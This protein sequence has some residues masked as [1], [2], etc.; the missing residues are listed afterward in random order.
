M[1][2]RPCA[3]DRQYQNFVNAFTQYPDQE[4]LNRDNTMNEVEE[5]FQ[6]RVD[7]KPNMHVGRA[8]FITDSQKCNCY[9]SQMELPRMRTWYL[10]RI[11]IYSVPRKSWKYSG[12]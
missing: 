9:T 3:T 1:V 12:F 10:F 4:E 7:I 8:I 5:Y 11:P 2:I 6:Y